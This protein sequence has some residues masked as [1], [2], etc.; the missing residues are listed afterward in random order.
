MSARIYIDTNIYLDYCDRRKDLIRPLHEFAFD[1]FRRTLQC[2]FEIV[3][4]NFVLREIK[5]N[6]KNEKTLDL[7]LSDL[8]NRGKL[9]YLQSTNADDSKARAYENWSDALH[10]ILARK[11]NCK[12]IVTRNLSDFLQFSDI[13]EPKLPEQL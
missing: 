12:Y 2:E 11:A 8:K 7:L 4:S 5:R 13:L 1:L 10:A 3:I 9:V 6:I